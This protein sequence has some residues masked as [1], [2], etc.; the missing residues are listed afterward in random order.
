MVAHTEDSQVPLRPRPTIVPKTVNYELCTLEKCRRAQCTYAHSQSELH[1]WF[2][3]R[4]K[5]EPRL[6]HPTGRQPP[7]TL[8]IH[9]EYCKHGV[10][11][12]FP[13]SRLEMKNWEKNRYE[14]KPSLV[15]FLERHS[16]W[17]CNF[18]IFFCSKQM[19]QTHFIHDLLWSVSSLGMCIDNGSITCESILSLHFCSCY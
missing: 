1:Y 6:H 17:P 10:Q 3:M 19:F 7:Y 12:L 5:E 4:V 15:T 18:K 11:C 14:C 13:H 9:W 2:Q 8:C 16:L